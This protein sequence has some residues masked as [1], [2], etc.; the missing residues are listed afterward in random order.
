DLLALRRAAA[1][2][3]EY[4]VSDSLL[5]FRGGASTREVRDELAG[6]GVGLEAVRVEMQQV[7]YAVRVSS[8]PGRGARLTIAVLEEAPRRALTQPTRGPTS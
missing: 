6:S 4:D 8:E 3:G 7:G 5:P 2:S 1:E